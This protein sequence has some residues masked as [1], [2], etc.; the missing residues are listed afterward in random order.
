QSSGAHDRN[1]VWSPDGS[2]LAWFSDASGEYQ[3]ILGDPTGHSA[4]RAVPLP[5][6]AFFSD[7][8]WS[9]DGKQLLFQD[10]HLN[11]WTM[12]LVNMKPTRRTRYAFNAPPHQP[13]A[14]W[15]PDSRWI[16]YS[17]VLDN[18][19]RAVFIYS[20]ADGKSHQLTDGMSDAI[21]PAFD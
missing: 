16:S 21:S 15:S 20:L 18:H 6:A 7:L 9:P 13:D 8:A 12:D 10:N 3:L 11:L 4:S 2:Q 5:S 14:V 17:K 19:M 1:P